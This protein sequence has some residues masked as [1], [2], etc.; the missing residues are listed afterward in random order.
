MFIPIVRPLQRVQPGSLILSSP[1]TSSFTVPDYDNF[2]VEL[3]GGGASGA[4]YSD[5]DDRGGLAG[6]ATSFTCSGPNAFTLIGGGAAKFSM[7][8][9]SGGAGGT[10]SGG[11]VNVAGAKGGPF[12]QVESGYG[13]D[14]YLG[15]TGGPPVS[16]S[17]WASGIA[18]TS[19]GA[20]GSGMF[21]K[22]SFGIY[23][24]AGGGAGGYVKKTWSRDTSPIL[25]LPGSIVSIVIGAGGASRASNSNTV[26]SGAGAPGKMII[27]WY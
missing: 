16:G 2:V 6:G 4:G 5:T 9:T 14:A 21:R 15:G 1:G 25:I 24:M 8:S 22:T 10:A 19:P 11:D 3:W 18:G 7:T 23:G 13:G 12:N 17:G 26:F 20:G 27:S